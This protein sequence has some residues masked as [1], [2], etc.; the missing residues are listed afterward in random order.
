MDSRAVIKRLE[1]DGWFKVA[2]KGSH[3][4][5]RHPTKP[6]RVIV[7]HPRQDFPIGT[8]KSIEN[9]AGLKLR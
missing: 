6:G 7:T 4:K 3:V 2:Q 8:L 5:F 9:Q 1:K